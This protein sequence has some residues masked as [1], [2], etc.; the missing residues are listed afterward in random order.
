MLCQRN[1]ADVI[2]F[3]LQLALQIR[4]TAVGLHGVHLLGRWA[5]VHWSAVDV[6]DN[7]S[8][9]DTGRVICLRTLFSG[10]YIKTN[11]GVLT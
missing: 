10:L 6:V 11:D 8:V 4:A 1:F 7:N 9:V 5:A 2:H 3:H